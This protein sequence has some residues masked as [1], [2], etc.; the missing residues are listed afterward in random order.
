M[1]INEKARSLLALSYT[2]SSIIYNPSH[3]FAGMRHNNNPIFLNNPTSP[4]TTSIYM[5]RPSSP[6]R[7]KNGEKSKRQERVG[8]LIRSEVA[9]IIHQGYSI[10]TDDTL[11]DDLRQKISIVDV[12]MS[13]DLRQA[14]ITISVF[15]K[16]TIQKRRAYSW[17]VKSTNQI[18]HALAQRTKHMKTCPN[19]TFVHADVGSAV[20]VMNLIDKISTGYKRESIDIFDGSDDEDDWI[21]DY[22]DE[23]E[24]IGGIG[25]KE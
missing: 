18:K 16:E 25:S 21:D 5:G 2:F 15:G 4:T 10:K 3:S 24:M 23:E 1:M 6:P 8:H 12:D 19:L 9:T 20:D 17:L 7:G 11:E 22:D 14:R 13:P